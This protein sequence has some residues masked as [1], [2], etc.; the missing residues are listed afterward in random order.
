[1]KS[2]NFEQVNLKLK[3]GDNPNTNDLDA[4]RCVNQDNI[5]S[6]VAKFKLDEDEIKRIS[7]TGELWICMMGNQWPPVLPT[8]HHPFDELGFK[9]HDSGL[10]ATMRYR[11]KVDEM[12]RSL[13]YNDDWMNEDLWNEFL[14][15][16]GR[17]FDFVAFGN[18]IEEAVRNGHSVTEKLE[19]CKRVML[20]N[21]S[22]DQIASK[23][24]QK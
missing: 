4:C 24:R 11:E 13:Y 12:L 14:S 20:K 9:I 16:M 18:I 22:K 1:M 19:E 6:I 3:A 23:F 8:I 2:E 15:S 5:P 10:P 17:K 7:E 21:M